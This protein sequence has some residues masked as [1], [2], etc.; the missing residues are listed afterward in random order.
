MS[1]LLDFVRSLDESELIILKELELTGK[2]K[3]IRDAYALHKQDKKFSEAALPAKLALSQSHFDKINSVLLDKTITHFYGD[4]YKLALQALRLKGL[5]DL[6]LHEL[7]IT[8]RRILRQKALRL[9]AEFYR[10]AFDTMCRMFH[11]HYNPV[12]TQLYGKK[13]LQSLGKACT[14]ADEAYIEL[15]RLQADMIAQSVAGNEEGY[16]GEAKRRV[17][18]WKKKI[19]KARNPVASFFYYYAYSQYIKYYGTEVALFI[20]ALEQALKELKACP[21]EIEI[22]FGS[23]ILCELGFGYSEEAD[24]EKS[25]A[26]YHKAFTQAAA[27]PKLNHYH[28]LHYMLAALLTNQIPIAKKIGNERL[29][30]FLTEGVNRSVRFDIVSNLFVLCLHLKDYDEAFEYLKELRAYKK[31]EMTRLGQVFLRLYETLYFYVTRQYDIAASF[32]GKN[33]KFLNRPENRSEQTVYFLDIIDCIDKLIKLKQR[34][35]Q[36]PK[37]L[38]EKIAGLKHGLY[39]VYNRLL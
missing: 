37:K 22:Q 2:E 23:R 13:Y 17:D 29:K 31:N 4:D 20:D 38:Q 9:D 6:M 35:L 34:R 36:S 3:A 11:P 33:L 19:E 14:I 32:A 28:T 1:Y 25:F 27:I 39:D 7:K 18:A 15:I 8:E 26:C 16:R 24:F 12:L 21:E 10:V 5:S 30:P